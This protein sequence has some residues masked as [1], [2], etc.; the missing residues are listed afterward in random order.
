MKRVAVAVFAALFL[1][2]DIAQAACVDDRQAVRIMHDTFWDKVA[3]CET[4]GNWQNGGQWA[5]GLGIYVRTWNN[6]GGRE[7]ARH[8]S[9]ATREEQI[10]VANR[11]SAIG[12]QTKNVYRTWED[13]I[14]KRPLF[15][16]P[17]G[18]FGWGC[19]KQNPY[20]HPANYKTRKQSCPIK[21]SK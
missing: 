9:L 12:Y 4:R 8:P 15:R 21:S 14:N 2:P 11:I 10:I 1:F 5:G 20:L 18:Y 3:Q 16:R 6:F 13:R 7:F 19:I 17:V